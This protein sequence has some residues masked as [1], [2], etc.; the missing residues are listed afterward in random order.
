MNGLWRP[1]TCLGTAVGTP[2]T[3]LAPE[4]QEAFGS[5]YRSSVVLIIT[6][7]LVIGLIW[8]FNA[9][10]GDDGDNGS[11]QVGLVLKHR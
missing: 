9:C 6:N 2:S 3:W 1:E 8:S 7:S 10:A 11:T 5:Y 4:I